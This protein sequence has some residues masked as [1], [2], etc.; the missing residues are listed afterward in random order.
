[1]NEISC[2]VCEDLIP[3]VQDGVASRGSCQAVEQ[4]VAACPRC[5]SLLNGQP[6]SQPQTRPVV[7]RVQS[8]MRYFFALLLFVGIFFGVS[9]TQLSG[10]FS[11]IFL[12]PL[13]GAM[14]YGVYRWRALWIVPLLLLMT[15]GLAQTILL[16]NGVIRFNLLGCLLWTALTMVFSDIGVLIAGLFHFGFRKEYPDE[17]K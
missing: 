9:M 7:S 4:H 16:M 14:A 8:K 2:E 3:L 1:M 10:K 6:L 12:M 15:F 17:K 5:R 13:A 11:V